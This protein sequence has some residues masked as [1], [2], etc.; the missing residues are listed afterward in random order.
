MKNFRRPPFSEGTGKRYRSSPFS[1]FW[2][3]HPQILLSPPAGNFSLVSFSKSIKLESARDISVN[4]ADDR[5]FSRLNFPLDMQ[6][7]RGLGFVPE[8]GKRFV[9]ALRKRL[10]QTR[11]PSAAIRFVEVT[12]FR[13]RENEV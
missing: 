12:W 6:K 3:G 13:F 5:R 10:L 4:I 8:S 11:I 7:L 9:R 2:N 1:C